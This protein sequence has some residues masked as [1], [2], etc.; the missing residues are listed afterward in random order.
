MGETEQRS[1]RTQKM[2]ECAAD[3][4]RQRLSSMDA[5]RKSTECLVFF[6]EEKKK[7]GG[8]DEKEERLKGMRCYDRPRRGQEEAFWGT[9][10]TKSL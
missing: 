10:Q 2:C 1:P 4:R 3:G 9:G 5:E 7:G 8:I 6:T